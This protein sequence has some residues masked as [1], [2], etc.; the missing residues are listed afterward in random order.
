[1]KKLLLIVFLLFLSGCAQKSNDESPYTEVE[2]PAPYTE[3]KS[4]AQDSVVDRLS[5]MEYIRRTI[6]NPNI[7]TGTIVYK[8]DSVLVIDVVSRVEV[9]IIKQVSEEITNYLVSLT[10][11]T[12]NGLI[13]NE[14]IPVGDIMY[15]DLV[16]LQPDAFTIVK[17]N[18]GDQSVDESTVTEWIWGITANKVGNFDLIL[19][20]KIKNN[21]KDIIIFDKKINVKNIPKKKYSM[22]IDIPSSLKRYNESI[23]KL[24]I[25][26]DNSDSFNF[27]WG[28]KGKVILDFNGKIIITEFNNY[29]IDDN[30]SLFNYKW[31]VE[32]NGKEK[33]ILYTITIVG[34]YEE[35]VI[36]NNN[37]DVDR[38]FQKS[39]NLFID[40]VAKRWYWI[41][42][43]LLIPIYGYLKKKYFTK[44]EK[45]N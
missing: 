8:V 30:K 25:S 17:V 32:P 10:T 41:F 36:Y 39:F 16:T 24:S 44:K 40:N 5:G 37:I 35:L 9:R 2:P 1:M 28:G 12:S 38:N 22:R 19:R 42:S 31:I 21:V 18:S 43:A 27:E 45:L 13:K 11:H 3:I 34:D 23:I 33:N 4:P 26:R 7:N 6:S 15:M 14:T 29:D 20:A